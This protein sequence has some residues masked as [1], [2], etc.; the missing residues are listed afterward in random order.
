MMTHEISKDPLDS[1]KAYLRISI[2]SF[3]KSCLSN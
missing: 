2:K 3:Y 1:S